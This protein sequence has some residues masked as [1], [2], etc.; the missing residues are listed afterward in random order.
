VLLAVAFLVRGPLGL[1]L[2]P[3]D[4]LELSL[5]D[6]RDLLLL[7]ITDTNHAKLASGN[8]RSALLVATR[9]GDLLVVAVLVVGVMT[10]IL[11]HLHLGTLVGGR[12]VVQILAIVGAQA[13]VTGSAA[14]GQVQLKVVLVYGLRCAVCV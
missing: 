13:T 11:E 8:K 6:S 5:L 12:V 9:A 1:S 2:L 3:L 7:L 14:R 10:R 4:A